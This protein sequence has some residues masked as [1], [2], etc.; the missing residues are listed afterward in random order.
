MNTFW[1]II[2]GSNGELKAQCVEFGEILSQPG[3]FFLLFLYFFFLLYV[4]R[5]SMS[6]YRKSRTLDLD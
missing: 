2:A 6:S 5:W 3:L 1:F 4:G